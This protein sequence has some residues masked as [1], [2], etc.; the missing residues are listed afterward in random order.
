MPRLRRLRTAVSASDRQAA[1]DRQRERNLQH[2]FVLRSDP[3]SIP[4]SAGG[5]GFKP[6]ADW[7]HAQSLKFG[8]HIVR[9][10]LRQ[11][12]KENLPIAGS[13]FHAVDAADTTDTC[14]WDDGNWGVK[15]NSAGQAYYDGML[16][17][18]AGWGL[19]FVKV[20]C[21]SDHLPADG[22][23]AGCRGYPED[24]PPDCAKL[25]G[26]ADEPRAGTSG[27]CR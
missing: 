22:D 15:D 27:P 16:K 1:N 5:V 23:K 3:H 6:L 24:G 7:V 11:V 17:L 9:G 4:S 20:D 25:D 14:P 26:L 12:V 2:N 19:D 21:I 18:Y 10:I 13:S 8:I